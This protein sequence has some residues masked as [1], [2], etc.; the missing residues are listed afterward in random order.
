MT[1]KPLQ[2]SFQS[3]MLENLND[4]H[5]ILAGFFLYGMVIRPPGIFLCIFLVL[6]IIDFIS[7]ASLV[8]Y[9]IIITLI[10]EERAGL[11]VIVYQ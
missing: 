4:C 1:M 3:V 11:Y 9:S 10:G 8:L 6:L 5:S 2:M 7:S